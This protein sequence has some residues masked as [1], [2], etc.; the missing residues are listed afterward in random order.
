MDPGGDGCAKDL[1]PT[2]RG[3]DNSD[4]FVQVRVGTTDSLVVRGLV[5]KS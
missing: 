4:E 3:I 2:G 1:K 5:Q